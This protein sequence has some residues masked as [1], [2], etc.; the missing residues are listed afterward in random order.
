VTRENARTVAQVCRRLDGI[1]L[2]IELAAAR[3]RVLSVEQIAARLDDRFRLLGAPHRGALP[4]QQTLRAAMD[5]SYD[6]LSEAERLLLGRLSVF[7]GG[8]TLEAAEEICADERSADAPPGDRCQ[9][10]EVMEILDLLTGL[11]NKSLVLAEEEVMPR[12]RLLETIRQYGAEKLAG[13]SEASAS[14]EGARL[15]ARH[16]EWFRRLAEEA[17]AGLRGSAQGEW[18]R[19]LERERDNLRAAIRFSLAQGEAG[20]DA[21]EWLPGLRLGAALA[22]YWEVRGYWSEGREQLGRLLALPGAEADPARARALHGAGILAFFQGDYAAA[23]ALIEE[24]LAAPASAAD[25]DARASATNSLGIV[26]L[27]Q[28]EYAAARDQYERSL[29]LR[30]EIGDHA[31]MASTLNNLG[32]VAQYQG[33][34][35][36]ARSLYGESLI[37]RR[38]LGDQGSIGASLNNLGNVAFLQG[39]YD[40]AAALYEESLAIKRTVGD[41]PGIA[42]TLDNLGLIAQC[43]GE[44]RAA[45]RLHRE[46]LALRRELGDRLGV[47]HSLHGMGGVARAM[48]DGD[49]A[50]R[51]YAESLAIARELGDRQAAAATLCSMA[52]VAEDPAESRALLRESLGHRREL[53]DRSGMVECLEGMAAL[54][55]A[56][57]APE[58]AARLFGAAASIREQ[59]RAPILPMERDLQEQAVQ[60]TRAVLG[61]EAFTAAWEQGRA[62]TL[63]AAAAQ[64]AE[65]VP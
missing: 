40:A 19:R 54:A 64:A 4:H 18:M 8:F 21:Q 46:S 22:R 12:Y 61:E 9:G 52:R 49:E 42:G 27:Y 20:A 60:R 31:G 7:A 50:R 15:R 48:G 2:A 38:E 23:R 59:L 62:L 45:G 37:L 25:R 13:G 33:D 5:W 58:R 39:D 32:M 3:V 11:V 53:G 30:R 29:A 63:E 41:R 14:G 44:P 28:G 51:W 65:D 6:L 43:R 24:C 36:A 47:A 56:T 26:A 57:G 10:L 16:R 55:L 34:Y 17:Q 1:P 35:D